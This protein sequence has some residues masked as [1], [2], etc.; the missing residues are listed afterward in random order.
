MGTNG[1][2]AA[3]AT[4]TSDAM[5]V[6]AANVQ[7]RFSLTQGQDPIFRTVGG[8]TATTALNVSTLAGR[9]LPIACCGR[10]V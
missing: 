2:R 3:H 9:S 1:A 5:S 4:K 8:S 10:A 7:Q 6:A